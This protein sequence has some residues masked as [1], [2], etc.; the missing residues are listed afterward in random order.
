M[1]RDMTL[2]RPALFGDRE[3]KKCHTEGLG[4]MRRYGENEK[5]TTIFSQSESVLWH[6]VFIHLK[7][8]IFCFY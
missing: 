4:K 1:V 8:Y 3:I 2:I 7:I 5:K 6:F